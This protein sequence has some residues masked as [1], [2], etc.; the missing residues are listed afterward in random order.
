MKKNFLVTT[1][2]YYWNGL[3]HVGHFY[4]STIANVIYKYHKIS[5]DHSRFT[6]GI[7]ENSQK[8]IIK[9]E[10]AGMDIMDY[11]DS[12][13]SE[14]RKVWDHFN[15]DY[16][17]FVRTT[18][19]RHHEVVKK[20]LDH[21]HSKWDIYEWEYEWMY[22]VWCEAFKKDEDLVFLNKTTNE[23][24]PISDKVKPS[25]NIIKVCP[26]HLKTPD[27][28]KEKNY[29]FKLSKYQTWIEEFYAANPEFVN[30]DFRYNEVKAFVWR[31]LEDFSVSRETN[32]FGIKLPFDETQVTYVWFDAL[33]NYY[34]SC[35]KSRAW[36]KNNENFVDENEFWIRKDPE[37]GKVLHVVWKDIIRFHAIYWPAMLASYF[38]LW[39]EIDWVIHFDAKKDFSYLPNQIL[40]WGFFTVDW[41]KMSKSIW[42]VIEPVAYSEKYNKELLTLYM[43][44][45]FNI[46]RDWDYDRKDAILSYNAKLAN[47]FW[48]L[49]NRAVVLTLKLK[50]EE[51]L[52]SNV[53]EKFKWYNIDYSKD[54]DKPEIFDFK[55]W[56]NEY[57]IFFDNFMSLNTLKLALDLSFKFLDE[58]NLYVTE[59]EPWTLMKDETKKHQV[60]EIMYTICETLRNVSM[61]LYPFFPEKM[62]QVFEA[63][64]L[65]W[66]DKEL[67][68]WNLE[69]L[70]NRKITYKIL[71]KAPI[72]FEKFEI[73]K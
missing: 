48:N 17:D 62:T 1:P 45:A 22:C 44:S 66:Y 65:E 60:E 4:S 32:T 61:N 38:D 57:N 69:S 35:V 14:H 54:S 59:T 29:F 11:L 68:E 3:P 70:R 46:W 26:D 21:C 20:V 12:M 15:F 24:F 13:A 6:T 30:P 8:A 56:I 41:M 72:L 28:I 7:D 51:G 63:L 25:D 55:W 43:L 5:W 2:I 31:G 50:L 16:T 27:K 53:S 42:N 9:A 36:D 52:I 10:E 49:L 47:N 33:F 64:W 73:E 23:T 34:T 40:T 19:D 39:K 18:S 67:E 37:S 58:V 71:N